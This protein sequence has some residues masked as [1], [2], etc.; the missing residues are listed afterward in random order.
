MYLYLQNCHKCG[1]QES[2]HKGFHQKSVLSDPNI[3]YWR[4]SL[5]ARCCMHAWIE[6]KNKRGQQINIFFKTNTKNFKFSKIILKK[7][8]IN[9]LDSMITDWWIHFLTVWHIPIVYI[10]EAS[11]VYF[12]FYVI[13]KNEMYMPIYIYMCK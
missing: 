9:Y 4:H 7:L 6:I 13:Y 3:N 8:I 11:T 5:F 2:K 12:Y 1:I 10:Y